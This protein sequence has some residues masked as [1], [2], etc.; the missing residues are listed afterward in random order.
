LRDLGAY[1]AHFAHSRN[2]FGRVGHFDRGWLLTTID[3]RGSKRCLQRIT[4]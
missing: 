2:V 3:V 1:A 4:R